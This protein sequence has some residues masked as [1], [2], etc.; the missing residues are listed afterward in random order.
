MTFER[1]A[2]DHG[3]R[4]RA[5]LVAAY[6][7]E[8]GGEAAAEAIAYGFEHWERLAQMDNPVGYLYRVGQSAARRH[9][10]PMFVVPPTAAPRLPEFEPALVPALAALS[11]HQRAA[12]LL[13]HAFDWT[14]TEAAELLGVSLSTLRTHLRRGLDHLRSHLEVSTNVS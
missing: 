12:V 4:L 9:R 8:A 1:F 3:A 10:R 11:E 14:Q 7:P 13:V 2:R 5:G 6:G